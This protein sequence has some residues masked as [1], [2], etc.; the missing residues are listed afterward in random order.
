MSNDQKIAI[1]LH[2]PPAS[3]KSAIGRELLQR[4]PGEAGFIN[5]DDGWDPADWNY[6]AGP[7]GYSDVRHSNRG[8]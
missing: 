8:S 2:G 7:F 4:L 3:G 1:V 5:L 6:R